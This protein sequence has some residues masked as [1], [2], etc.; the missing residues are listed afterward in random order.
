[1][2]ERLPFD[3]ARTA[4][5]R[6]PARGD[7]PIPVA[8]LATRIEHAVSVGVPGPL[9]VVGE[10]SG[11]RERTHW[12]FDLKDEQAAV[13]CVVFASSARRLGF[14]PA[15]GDRVVARGRCS[16]YKPTGRVSF[17]IDHLEPAGAG[18]LDARFRALV[19]ELRG[20]GWFDPEA[21]QALP[22]FPRRVAVITSRTGAALQD[23]IDT[24]RRRCPAVGLLTVDVRVQGPSAAGEI[25]AAV[26]RIGADARTLGVDAILLT[27]GGGS[28]EDLWAFNERAVA[29]AIR[30]CPVPIVAAIGHETDT[31]IAEL[32]ADERAATPTQA[33]VR[34]TPD[35]AALGEQVAALERRLGDS[36]RA[37][38]RYQ[39]E[40]VRRVADRPALATPR[41]TIRPSI[42]RVRGLEAALVRAAER[43]VHARR[44][45]LGG[46]SLRL[47]RGRPASVH[48]RRQER[49]RALADR[50]DRVVRR[51]V[52]SARTR[53][54]L[55][56]AERALGRGVVSARVRLAGADRGLHAVGPVS[57]LGRGYTLT[58]DGEGV[59]VRSAKGL[60]AGDTLVTRFADG[61]A[62]SEVVEGAKRGR[63]STRRSKAADRAADGSQMDLFDGA[64]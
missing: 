62:R 16:F 32:V 7:E 52:G 24:A 45:T 60:R 17:V 12:Y 25:A 4:R 58:T 3:P 59:L 50:L 20:L 2:A 21:K 42:D 40:R 22:V 33:A 27:R 1:M 23:V 8:D 44:S 55:E 63:A 18:D 28:V 30:A 46:L 36:L 39:R 56:H 6:K 9:R 13:G 54:R 5:A 64:G 43:V 61:N 29:E 41:G 34:L 26:R 51:R 10:V 31:T 49:L 53:V 15:Q 11:F 37:E 19:E 47:E 14:T 38:V 57:V 48:A 35:R